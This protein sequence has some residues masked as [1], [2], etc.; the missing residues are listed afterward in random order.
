MKIM[1]WFKTLLLKI[2]KKDYMINE[3]NEENKTRTEKTDFVPKVDVEGIEQTKTREA[4]L[5]SLRDDIMVTDLSEYL[6]HSKF[7]TE[8]IRTKY[9]KGAILSDEDMTALSC[10]YG[11]IIEENYKNLSFKDQKVENEI[12]AFL[13]EKP[14]NIVTLINLMVKD[15]KKTYEGLKNK[16]DD[17]ATFGLYEEIVNNTTVQGL[18]SGSYEEI[19]EIIAEYEKENEMQEK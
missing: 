5:I 11:A 17:N 6:N 14:N 1:D 18:I 3:P 15:A 2:R 4:I 10:L 7:S 12:N 8:N 13:G 19:S 9:D 16:E